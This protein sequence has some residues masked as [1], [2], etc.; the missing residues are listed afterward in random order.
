MGNSPIQTGTTAEYD[1]AEL[2]VA[3]RRNEKVATWGAGPGGAVSAGHGGNTSDPRDAPR[4]P[5]RSYS[6]GGATRNDDE[7]TYD[8]YYTSTN[9]DDQY[10]D[11]GKK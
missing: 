3:P 8:E 6:D 5:L 11:D 4:E 2:D 7:E 1:S 10:I 9:R